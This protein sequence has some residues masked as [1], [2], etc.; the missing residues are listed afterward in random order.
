MLMPALLFLE[1]VCCAGSDGDGRAGGA[2]D[3]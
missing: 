2:V 3:L 1:R